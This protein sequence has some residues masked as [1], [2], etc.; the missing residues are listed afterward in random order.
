MN[1]GDPKPSLERSTCS[2]DH[3]FLLLSVAD[4]NYAEEGGWCH[5][6]HEYIDGGLERIEV[7]GNRGLLIRKARVLSEGSKAHVAMMQA[8]E[9]HQKH[10]AAVAD[11]DAEPGD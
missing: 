1:H 11:A 4:D 3:G 10:E 9:D 8:G 2:I 5:S 6:L 7:S